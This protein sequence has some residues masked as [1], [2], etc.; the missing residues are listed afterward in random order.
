MK[1][2]ICHEKQA[3]IFVRQMTGQTSLELHLCADCARER[4]FSAT[5]SKLELSLSGLLSGIV[6]NQSLLNS[7]N[8]ACPVCGKS[9]KDIIDNKKAG[10]PECY[11]NFTKEI[12]AQLKLDGIE[13][14]YTGSLP[15][16]LA[17]F[18]S[19]LTDRMLLQSKLEKAIHEEDY[20]KAAVYRDRLRVLEKSSVHNGEFEGEEGVENA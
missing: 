12:M 14:S 3:V 10:C 15:Q 5:D 11:I 17:H 8:R 6:D 16:Q 19:S 1:C 9:L 20:E 18:K 7:K 2:D 13:S 4:G